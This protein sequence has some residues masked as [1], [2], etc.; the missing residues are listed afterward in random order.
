[1]DFITFIEKVFFDKHSNLRIVLHQENRGRGSGRFFRFLPVRFGEEFTEKLIHG[2]G[3]ETGG[4]VGHGIG[5]DEFPIMNH[6]TT[7]VND[8]GNVTG[9]LIF[10]GRQQGLFQP[11]DEFGGVFM[12]QEY[13]AQTIRSHR[14]H[15]M[16]DHEPAVFGLY[17]G[18]GISNLHELPWVNRFLDF[19]GMMPEVNIIGEHH[20]IILAVDAGEHGIPAVDFARKQGK[21]FILY[22]FPVYGLDFEMIEVPG[23]KEFGE[24]GESVVSRIRGIVNDSSIVLGETDEPGIFD[25]VALGIRY[26]KQ[27]ALGE[28]CVQGEGHFVMGCCEPVD[29]LDDFFPREGQFLLFHGFR[30]GRLE[31]SVN[32]FVAELVHDHGDDI[33]SNTHLLQF[34]E[35]HLFLVDMPGDDIGHIDQF[36]GRH[37]TQVAVGVNNA[38]PEGDGRDMAFARG[39]EADNDPFLT[40]RQV[41][42]VGIFNNGRVE[43]CSRFDGVLL[44]EIGAYDDFLVNRQCVRI[45]VEFVEG[46]FYI[47]EIILKN[48]GD[49]PMAPGE[50]SQRL[51]ESCL[52]LLIGHAENFQND[53]PNPVIISRI[54]KVGNDSFGI[55]EKARGF[56][57]YGYGHV[58][59]SDSVVRSKARI[60]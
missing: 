38:A 51:I 46:M 54:E 48:P 2:H 28:R 37:K 11:T 8:V 16:R 35:E 12:V 18:A 60:K 56:S 1:M 14:T 42:L 29:G 31:L 17:G 47:I 22:D 43:E 20:I 9:T 21:A 50:V 55:G 24:D 15:T 58:R 27:N 10:I 59:T 52:A 36:A 32:E 3:G 40:V 25:P 7:G 53:I 30:N 33:F 5:N 26:G 19:F 4:V 6:G 13:G 45:D 44:G 49:I 34:A 41:P 39:P 23:L 57:V